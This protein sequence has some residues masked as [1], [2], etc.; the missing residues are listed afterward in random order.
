[1]K[2]FIWDLD[3]TLVDSYK[4][5]THNVYTV[6]SE[7]IDVTKEEIFTKI[8]EQSISRFFIDESKKHDLPL[9][10]LHKKY[11]ALDGG[12]AATAYPLIEDAKDVVE[13][14]MHE[15]D[16]HFIY[17]HRD[18][19]TL[20]II[21]VN[22]MDKLFVDIITSDNEFKRKPDSD[23]LDYLIQKYKLDKQTTYYVGD[24]LLD[25]E[26]GNNAGIQTIYFNPE[27]IQLKTANYNVNALIDILDI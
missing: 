1:M 2:T 7:Y 16:Q 20:D 26:C 13:S 8:T 12:V 3:G 14:L 10:V 9:H 11:M 5:I 6:F 17:T 21:Q 4:I 19:F 18:L 23:A 25:V 27:G 22:Q 24:R 15:G